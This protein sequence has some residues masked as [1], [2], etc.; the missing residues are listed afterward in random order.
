MIDDVSMRTGVVFIFAAML[1]SGLA[2]L[3]AGFNPDGATDSPTGFA[4]HP[5]TPGDANSGNNENSGENE[6]SDTPE[7]WE[8]VENSEYKT[9]ETSITKDDHTYT[10]DGTNFYNEKGEKVSGITEGHVTVSSDGYSGGAYYDPEHGVMTPKDV[11][12][13]GS[14]VKYVDSDG[15][16][17]EE[18]KGTTFQHDDAPA[19]VTP[20]GEFVYYVESDSEERE[21]H[22]EGPSGEV[23]SMTLTEK[24]DGENVDVNVYF[25]NDGRRVAEDPEGVMREVE[26]KGNDGTLT[27]GAEV[28]GKL[29]GQSCGGDGCI[30]GTCVGGVCRTDGDARTYNMHKHNLNARI[31]GAYQWAGYSQSVSSLLF[32]E[33]AF[34]EWRE[35]MDNFF[36]TEVLGMEL[37][38]IFGGN[39][40]DSV[41][42]LN[43]DIDD[44]Q[45]VMVDTG[46]GMAEF[47]MHIE[48]EKTHALTYINDSGYN[49]TERLYKVSYYVTNTNED[50]NRFNILFVKDDGES[51]FYYNIPENLS[52]GGSYDGTGQNMIVD[53][54]PNNYTKVCIWLEYAI[55][56]YEGNEEWQV[57]NRLG[58]YT[59]KATSVL[60]QESLGFRTNSGGSKYNGNW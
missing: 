42:H 60:E 57:C 13:S 51:V 25:T 27:Y 29:Y 38:G 53:Y 58:P 40:E 46:T 44:S 21:G 3:S 26:G 9:G 8:Y 56:D 5:N 31:Y 28:E 17:R 14:Q 15:N 7:G 33:D 39:W 16:L 24:R 37:G 50:D 30:A 11:L 54:S 20:D 32:E 2:F 10:W 59:G 49:V 48:G 1:L 23:T 41:C 43:F 45:T 22:W 6:N 12:H 55:E 19:T 36:A 47:G 35:M 34:S 52:A 4:V 18:T